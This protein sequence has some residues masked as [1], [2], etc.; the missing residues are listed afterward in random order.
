MVETKFQPHNSEWSPD[1]S[2]L[3]NEP[4][5]AGRDIGQRR[6][7]GNR[8]AVEKSG[9]ENLIPLTEWRQNSQSVMGLDSVLHQGSMFHQYGNMAGNQTVPT[10]LQPMWPPSVGLTS[11][12]DPGPYGPYWPDGAFV[13]YRPALLRDPQ[14]LNQ[15]TEAPGIGVSHFQ[16]PADN[17]GE[18]NA[19][20]DQPTYH[21]DLAEHTS[22]LIGG[23]EVSDAYLVA[24]SENPNQ[25]NI[26]SYT[27]DAHIPQ[28]RQ[29]PLSYRG[30]PHSSRCLPE[31]SI[32]RWGG[33]P[34]CSASGHSITSHSTFQKTNLYA[35][36][37]QF[38]DKVLVWA[39]RVYVSLLASTQYPRRNGSTSEHHN[40]PQPQPN[41]YSKPSR[42]PF[43]NLSGTHDCGDQNHEGLKNRAGAPQ[44]TIDTSSQHADQWHPFLASPNK[45]LNEQ[46]SA[47]QCSIV[48]PLSGPQRYTRQPWQPK[49]H[50]TLPQYS[51]V[52]DLQPVCVVPP[53][54][55]YQHE[56][57]PS[58]AAANALEM[59][60][61][62]CQESGW[63]WT[64]GML[65]GGCLAYGLG[66]H[67][68]AMKWYKKVLL[69][70]PK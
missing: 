25:N 61:R 14:Y 20:L 65:L 57:S 30:K 22:K 8:N 1:S 38:K 46:Y 68:K 7:I 15:I 40:D 4:N 24:S 52:P 35:S 10:A 66:D 31:P 26:F 45:L 70:D 51:A 17:G 43:S 50:E 9:N 42:Q 37:A 5:S 59:L 29:I 3:T 63:E 13:P 62:L 19:V 67:N 69:C 56:T 28:R 36:H 54:I 64:E 60:E 33:S 23:N 11:L 32:N 34:R 53:S 21:H 6:H 39:H 49:E 2:L 44:E 16:P 48:P 47:T 41:T 55:Q 12:N 18:W 58:G 27:Q